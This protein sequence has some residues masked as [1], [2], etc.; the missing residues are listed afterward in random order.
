SFIISLISLVLALLIAWVLLPYFN[1]LAGKDI[2]T[3]TLFQPKMLLSLIGLIIIVGILAG[4]YPA[5]FLS[6]FQPIDVLK[7][8]LAGGFKRSW[9]RNAL[10]VFQF[11]ISIALIFGTIVIYKQLNYIYNKDIGF[12]RNQVIV[13][14]NTGS[15]G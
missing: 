7:G 15:L 5:F 2:H 11:F 13:I 1:Q 3:S 9:L 6:A 4:S 10:V 12:D 14:N 8:K